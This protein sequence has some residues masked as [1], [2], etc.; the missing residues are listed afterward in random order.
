MTVVYKKELRR[1]LGGVSGY[2]SMALILLACGIYVGV[3]NLLMGVADFSYPLVGSFLAL[4]VA[5]PLLCEDL[6]VTERQSGASKTWY[7]LSFRPVDVVLGKY[8]AVLTV[9]LLAAAVLALY[10]L[11][12]S[13]FGELLLAKAYFSW[14]GYVLLGASLL[15]ICTFISAFGAR[16]SIPF[17]VSVGVM[18]VLWLLQRFVT[19][20]PAAP[21]FSYLSVLLL[22]GGVVA[23]FWFAVESRA[24]ALI[25]AVLFVPTTVLFAVNQGMFSSLLARMLAALNPY[26]R[27]S[28]FVYGSFD[29]EGILFYLSLTAFFLLATVLLLCYRRR[30][31]Q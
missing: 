15:A 19:S 20:L 25:S 23:Y 21:L 6:F 30:D 24:A 11:L 14:F 9:F 28:N 4:I 3:S 2:A 10:P 22:L 1:L 5:M 16:R 27:Y 12:L 8:L 18:L 26:S 17:F 31:E 13:L 7:A 29:L